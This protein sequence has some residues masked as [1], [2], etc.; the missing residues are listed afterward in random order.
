MLQ[1]NGE[2]RFFVY[3][4]DYS[5]NVEIEFLQRAVVDLIHFN[6]DLEK[7]KQCK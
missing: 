4:C 1:M 7:T 5:P 3:V 6:K 2:W